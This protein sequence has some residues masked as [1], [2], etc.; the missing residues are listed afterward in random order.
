M[1][2]LS[3]L[4]YWLMAL[5]WWHYELLLHAV[6]CPL[7]RRHLLRCTYGVWTQSIRSIRLNALRPGVRCRPCVYTTRRISDTVTQSERRNIIQLERN[8]L[9]YCFVFYTL[10]FQFLWKRLLGWAMTE[11]NIK[12]LDSFVNY[13]STVYLKQRSLLIR[14][15]IEMAPDSCVEK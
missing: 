1:L 8:R 13:L 3:D 15:R 7:G 2:T 10:F 12:W 4:P 6:M 14:V 11:L 9:S 5:A